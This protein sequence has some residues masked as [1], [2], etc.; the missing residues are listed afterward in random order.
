MNQSFEDIH[1]ETVDLISNIKGVQDVSEIFENP[2]KYH[3]ITSH[4][5]FKYNVEDKYN[6]TKGEVVIA[7]KI[8][9][10]FIPLKGYFILDELTANNVVNLVKKKYK[11]K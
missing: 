9:Q 2:N 8:K 4:I 7:Y 1:K 5:Y 11:L 3:D 6:Y 10:V